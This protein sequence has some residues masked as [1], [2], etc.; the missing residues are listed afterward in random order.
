MPLTRWLVVKTRNCSFIRCGRRCL[1]LC[2]LSRG[3]ETN[4]CR[5]MENYLIFFSLYIPH[6]PITPHRRRNCR[7]KISSVNVIYVMD[8][9]VHTAAE[10]K[11][12]WRKT[13]NLLIDASKLWKDMYLSISMSE[14]W[15]INTNVRDISTT[16]RAWVIEGEG[17]RA[18]WRSSLVA[19][20]AWIHENIV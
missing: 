10:N 18:I 17:E 19:C 13:I 5:Y 11:L 2:R 7:R 3:I 9:I 4:A 1:L 6:T 16:E 12:K 14:H 20:F 15:I 8:R